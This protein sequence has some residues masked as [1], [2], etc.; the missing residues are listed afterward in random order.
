MAKLHSRAELIEKKLQGKY[1]TYPNYQNYII[2]L[3]FS[4]N[5]SHFYQGCLS[6][7]Y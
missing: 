2:P 4:I 5:T 6:V 1:Q 7:I 3:A